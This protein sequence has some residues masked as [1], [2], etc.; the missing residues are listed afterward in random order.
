[1]LGERRPAF[2]DLSMP[3]VRPKRPYRCDPI[4]AAVNEET[5][6]FDCDNCVAQVLGN[7]LRRDR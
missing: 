6:V 4:D 3:Q 2:L 1:L 7:F 5:L